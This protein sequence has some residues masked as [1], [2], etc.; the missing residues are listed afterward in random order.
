MQNKYRIFSEVGMQYP[1]TDPPVNG[2]LSPLTLTPNG[3]VCE[4]QRAYDTEIE[5]YTEPDAVVMFWIGRQDKNGKDVYDGDIVKCSRGCAHEVVWMQAVPSSAI[6][7]GGM[8]GYYLKG[9]NEGY[10]WLGS[11]EVIGNIHQ[12]PERLEDKS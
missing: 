11:E 5:Y 7:G 12:H 8:P 1:D 2:V 3:Y 4:M 9:L 10:A 6:L